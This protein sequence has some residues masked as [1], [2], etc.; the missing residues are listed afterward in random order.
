M[1]VGGGGAYTTLNRKFKAVQEVPA[2]EEELARAVKGKMKEVA[3]N[4]L[5]INNPSSHQSQASLDEEESS[6][7]TVEAGGQTDTRDTSPVGYTKVRKKKGREEPWEGH[8][9]LKVH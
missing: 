4:M 8:E 6:A 3:D 2:A 1:G 5:T 7:N 9:P